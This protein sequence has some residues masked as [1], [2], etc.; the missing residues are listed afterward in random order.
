MGLY[1]TVLTEKRGGVTTAVRG[2][3]DELDADTLTGR[4]TVTAREA[5]EGVT[6]R[7]ELSQLIDIIFTFNLAFLM[8]MEITAASQRHLLTRKCQNKLS[9]ILQ[10]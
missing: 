8:V 5:E 9:T 6:M 3:E 4:I 10:E 2:A 1:V 7:A